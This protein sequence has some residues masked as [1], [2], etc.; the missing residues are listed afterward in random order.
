MGRS[1]RAALAA[2]VLT[3]ALVATTTAFA[4]P[5]PWKTIDVGLQAEQND[6]V[7]RV[8]CELATSTPLPAQ[9]EISVP[10]GSV[11][12]WVGEVQGDWTSESP[13][14]T[15]TTTTA[16]GADIYRFTLRSSRTA[17]LYAEAPPLQADGAS[18]FAA[19][20]AWVAGQDM[21]QV[22]LGA[23]VP[24]NARITKAASGAILHTEDAEFSYYEK[25]V[26]NVK[27]GQK[28]DLKFS[29][30]V[31][32]AAAAATGTPPKNSNTLILFIIITLCVACLVIGA[33]ALKTNRSGSPAEDPDDD[34][35]DA[36]QQ[37]ESD[38]AADGPD[39]DAPAPARSPRPTRRLLITAGL[40]AVFVLAAT[41]VGLQ[42]MKPAVAGDTIS[43]VF[44]G[45]E[46][47][48]TLVIGVGAP[49]GSDPV[50]T[51]TR[52]FAALKPV[53]GINDASFSIK[54]SRLE[55]G[56][57]ESKTSEAQIRAALAP[58]GFRLST[59]AAS[60]SAETT[61]S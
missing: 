38:D 42:V 22:S 58:L 56:Y 57:C 33:V 52:L 4:A 36:P 7:M 12:L 23:W 54:A 26:S 29:F 47:C 35:G 50:A 49:D 6:G 27:A 61:G 32:A 18:G 59:P 46:P 40:L 31:P 25:I 43:Q 55:V 8:W 48:A 34:D 17:H 5:V 39:A 28:L 11:P 10:A 24:A 3:L 19:S 41:L 44:A 13:Q 1:L 45:G 2:V 51:A 20:L 14:S 60:P 15:Y 16:N 37:V 21:A 9:V 53:S 30:L